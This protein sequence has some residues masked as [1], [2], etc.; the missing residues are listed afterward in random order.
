[1]KRNFFFFIYSLVGFC[2]LSGVSAAQEPSQEKETFKILCGGT[3]LEKATTIEFNRDYKLCHHLK[4]GQAEYFRI[5]VGP[6]VAVTLEARTFDKGIAW[7]KNQ[8]VTTS[9]PFAGLQLLDEE[10]EVLQSLE[11]AGI[12]QMTQK[13]SFRNRGAKGRDYY[14]RV[15][16]EKGSIHK[17]HMAFKVTTVPFALGD[18]GTNQD[19]GT[20]ALSALSVMPAQRYS[21]NLIGGGDNKDLFSFAGGEDEWYTVAI[22]SKEEITSPIKVQVWTLDKDKKKS[23]ISYVSG[24]A[25]VITESFEIPEDGVY[26]IE[27]TPTMPLEENGLYTLELMP[28]LGRGKEH[29]VGTTYIEE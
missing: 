26:F 7:N 27:V 1:M 4:M 2:L 16:S 21:H 17:K 10:K 5:H 8:R 25:Q 9:E 23:I 13:V 19:S 24:G 12:P 11:I 18:L 29:F 15:G 6:D 20:S 14:V 28:A 3:N 22:R